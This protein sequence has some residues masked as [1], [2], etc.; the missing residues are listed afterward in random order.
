M[1]INACVVNDLC[2]HRL[3]HAGVNT[4]CAD[5][6]SLHE[7]DRKHTR[8]VTLRLVLITRHANPICGAVFCLEVQLFLQPP[9]CRISC[10][11]PLNG[12]VRTALFWA[13]TFLLTFRDKRR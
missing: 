5:G 6:L 4:V 9:S 10:T 2:P 7:E 13:V 3:R 11:C 12:E 1:C 8:N